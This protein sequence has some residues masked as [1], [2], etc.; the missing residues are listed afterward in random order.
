M[1]I[2]ATLLAAAAGFGTGA[3]W[4]G[5]HSKRWL[6][7]T[8]RTEEEIKADRSPLPFVLAGVTALL[9]ST[10]LGHVLAGAGVGFGGALVSGVGFGFALVAPWIVL[11]HAFAGRPRDL[12][13]IDAGYAA[14]AVTVMSA[15]H[16][17]F[18]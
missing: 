18:L 17:L 1:D 5:I 13:W 4:Y 6:A 8:G 15:V 10:V 12:W 11:N 16:G 3:V 7:G 14:L 9:A 2:L